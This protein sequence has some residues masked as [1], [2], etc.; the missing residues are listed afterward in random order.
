MEKGELKTVE[1]VNE[2]GT[3]YQ[4]NPEAD[5]ADFCL[6]YLTVHK[7]LPTT[8]QPVSA[9]SPHDLQPPTPISP[10][11]A[12]PHSMSP[13]AKL[14]SLMGRLI[15]FVYSYSKKAMQPLQFRNIDDPVYLIALAQM[16]TPK[17]SELI[18]EML[19]E[20]P[21]GIDIIKRLIGMELIEEFPDEFDR[22]S[23]RLR[24]TEKGILALQRCFPEMNKVADIAFGTLT[25]EEQTTLIR[26]LNRLDSHHAEHYK[27]L[28][29]ATF[30]EVYERMVSQ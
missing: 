21:S 7:K 6:H 26:I 15:R 2:W 9:L 22:R 3:Y 23:K 8:T 18:N 25:L 14:A 19:S 27:D 29:N 12:A 5:L 30:E 20:F 17:K 16:G 28:R 4:Q 10:R 13:E 11:Q 24:I 1:L